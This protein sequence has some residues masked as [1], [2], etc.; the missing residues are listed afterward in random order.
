MQNDDWNRTATV[1]RFLNGNFTLNPKT[2]TTFYSQGFIGAFFSL[3]FG[4]KNLPFLTLLISILNFY[5][6]AKI[7]TKNFKIKT[8]KA[9]IVSLIFFFTPLN[10]YSSIG[11]MTENYTMLF[12]LLSIYL[13]LEYEKNYK[14]R[15][16]LLFNLSGML[17]FFSKQNG[18][19]LQAAS[20]PYF[21]FKKK[22]KEAL[23]QTFFIITIFG[24]YYLFFPRTPEMRS[25]DFVFENLKNIKYAY[26]LTYG[27]LL[28]MTS[29]LLPLLLNLIYKTYFQQ[30]INKKTLLI[31]LGIS[32]FLFFLLNQLFEPRRL[33]IREYPYFQ[34]T[35]ERTGFLPRSLMGT[36]YQFIGNYKLYLFWDFISKIVLALTL[37]CIFFYRKKILNIYSISIGG[38]ILL[39]VFVK[40]FYDRYLLPLFPLTILFLISL[41]NMKKEKLF[42]LFTLPFLLFTSFFSIQLATDFI[43]SNNYIWSKSEEIVREFDVPPERIRGGRAWGKLHDTTTYELENYDYLFSFDSPEKNPENMKMFEL[44]EVKDVGVSGSIFIDPKV[45]LYKKK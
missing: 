20:I 42:Y 18:I 34:N 28:V 15:D 41:E 4:F 24:Y 38:Y 10:I 39:M 31:Y 30:K 23:I 22:Y 13:F 21:L 35:F 17:A 25:K 43:I 8:I 16:L 33:W 11:F 3:V 9:N 2:A 36:K 7:L 40:V 14:F 44:I 19:I 26:S 29:Y 5:I 45:F 6:F 32:V 27:I 37:P 12:I 1:V